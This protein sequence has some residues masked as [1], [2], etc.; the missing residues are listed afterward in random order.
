MRTQ[1]LTF[2]SLPLILST[3]HVAQAATPPIK[4]GLWEVRN[5]QM[6]INGKPLPDMSAQMEQAMKSMPPE[7]RAKMQAQ[8]KANGVQMTG[9]AGG[10]TA[11]RICLTA[12][13]LDQ[14]RWQ[15]T[16]DSCKMS[17]I[18]KSGNTWTWKMQCDKPAGSG[19]GITTFA[20]NEAYS[21]QIRIKTKREGTM[22]M[23]HQ[24]KWIGANCMGIKPL[25]VPKP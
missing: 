18:N 17:D 1:W 13:M 5:D 11:M 4:P 23:K 25:A 10:G 6:L 14:D 22:E 2:I 12:E 9:G 16:N 8:M 21:T 19:E 24:A 15:N 3:L 7:V 20:S